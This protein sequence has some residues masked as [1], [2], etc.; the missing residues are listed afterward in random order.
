MDLPDPDAGKIT[1][2]EKRGV[3]TLRFNYPYE[4]DLAHIRTE[5]DLLSL[6]HRLSRESWMT[7]NRLRG[8]IDAI[9]RHKQLM[10]YGVVQQRKNP[11]LSVMSIP[12]AFRSPGTPNQ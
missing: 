8:V 9:A 2:D 4:I 10:L 3:C 5:A 6:I 7:A 1:I 11:W 12:M